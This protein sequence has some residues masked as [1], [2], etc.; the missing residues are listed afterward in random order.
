MVQSPVKPARSVK[1]PRM[2]RAVDGVVDLGVELH[3]V[4]VALR[5]R[6]DGEGG[7][8]R[9]ADHREAR[10]EGGDAVAVAHPDLLAAGLE[11]AR[12][13]RVLRLGGGDEGAAELGV[14]AGFDPAA[15]LGH[16]GLLAVADAEDGDAEGEDLRGGA[17]AAVGGDAGGAAGEDDGLRP[18]R[19]EEGGVDAVV[20]VDFAVDAQPR[21]A[22]GR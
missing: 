1:F 4:E 21:A 2:R 14:V 20:G 18:E 22:G 5:V 12:E 13:K 3:G 8:G 16:H 9:G 15:E 17:R 7:A 19:G 11:K 10:G 6:R